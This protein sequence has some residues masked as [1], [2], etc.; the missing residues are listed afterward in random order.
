MKR[1]VIIISVTLFY[2]TQLLI[3]LSV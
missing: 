3:L 2:Q 1:N